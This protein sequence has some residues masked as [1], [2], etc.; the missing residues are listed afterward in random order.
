[1]PVLIGY[2]TPLQPWN[3]HHHIYNCRKVWNSWQYRRRWRVSTC[4]CRLGAWT[5]PPRR[6]SVIFSAT[7]AFLNSPRAIGYDAKWNLFVADSG[8]N[9]G[10]YTSVSPPWSFQRML[11]TRR[12]SPRRRNHPS[13]YKLRRE[14][15]RRHGFYGRWGTGNSGKR[16]IQYK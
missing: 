14:R 7:S 8:N 6:F 13:D 4:H 12:C 10:L 9:R 3:R 16:L 2:S 15:D 5:H 11:A 1:M